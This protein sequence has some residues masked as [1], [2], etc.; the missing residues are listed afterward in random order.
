MR[1]TF[2]EQQATES[3]NAKE[4]NGVSLSKG[5]TM[6]KPRTGL[7]I[8]GHGTRSERGL[9]EFREAVEL[10]ARGSPGVPVAGCFLE[11]ARPSIK[12]G[13]ARLVADGCQRIVVLPLLLFAAGHAKQDIPAAVQAAARDYPQLELALAEHLG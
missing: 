1:V 7:L 2:A 3:R 11:L 9:A 10:V 6:L 12:E 5:R 8:V 4:D 13:M